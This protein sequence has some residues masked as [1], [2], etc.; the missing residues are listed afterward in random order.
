MYELLPAISIGNFL[1]GDQPTCQPMTFPSLQVGPSAKRPPTNPTGH[2][3]TF[4]VYL[5]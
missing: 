4:L 1:L 5:I 3:E 2:T